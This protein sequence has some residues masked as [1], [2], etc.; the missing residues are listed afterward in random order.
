[1]R[2]TM[3]KKFGGSARCCADRPTI[4]RYIAYNLIKTQAILESKRRS[5]RSEAECAGALG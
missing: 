3:F 5:T 2:K 4:P 1:M